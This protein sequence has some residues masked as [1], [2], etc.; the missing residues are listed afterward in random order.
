VQKNN[1]PLRDTGRV[2][3]HREPNSEAQRFDRRVIPVGDLGDA[4]LEVDPADIL[5]DYLNS[6]DILSLCVLDRLLLIWRR[7]FI[8]NSGYFIR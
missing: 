8:S 1:R 5:G 3:Q 2:Q 4:L 6:F 7:L